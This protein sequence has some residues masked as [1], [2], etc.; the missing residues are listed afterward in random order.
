[1]CDKVWSKWYFGNLKL[2][3]RLS[4]C[5]PVLVYTKQQKSYWHSQYLQRARNVHISCRRTFWIINI[6]SNGQWGDPPPPPPPAL[7]SCTVLYWLYCVVLC[8]AA[9]TGRTLL[10]SRPVQWSRSRQQHYEAPAPA[11]PRSIYSEYS[12]YEGSSIVTLVLA[13]I[14]NIPTRFLMNV[15]STYQRFCALTSLKIL[16]LRKLLD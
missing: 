7:Y 8:P 6:L 1:M 13:W 10:W 3:S 14:H 11:G 12:G 4:F 15:E 2:T 9:C 16:R 5:L